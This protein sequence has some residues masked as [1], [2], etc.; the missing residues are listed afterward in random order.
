MIRTL[1]LAGLVF[2]GPIFA[3][4]SADEI[5]AAMKSAAEFYRGKIA[6]NGGYVYYT[7]PDYSKRLG[8]GVAAGDQ[9]WVQPPGTPSV[10][11]AYLKAFQATGD[12]F[13]LDSAVETAEALIYGQLESGAWTNSISFDPSSGRTAQ[14][15]NGKG[16]GRNF[17]TLDDGISQEAIQF[18]A[19]L[20]KETRFQNQAVHEAAKVALDALLNAQFPNGAFPQGWDETPANPG[21]KPVDLEAGF[22]EYDWKTE[23]RI[24]EY[25]DMYTLNDDL[26]LTVSETLLVAHKAYGEDRFANSLKQFGDF[27]IRAQ[28]PEPQPGWAQQYNYDMKP[29]WARKFEPA[30]MSGRETEGVIV[31]LMRIAVEFRDK[32]YLEPIPKA[33]Q[34]LKRSELPEEKFARYYELITN[35]P[36]YM[37]RQGKVYTLT[38]DDSNLP[39]HYGWKTDSRLRS[40]GAAY[41]EVMQSGKLPPI[42]KILPP[43]K[44]DPTVADVLSSLDSEGRWVSTFQGEPL[45]GQPKFQPG[46]KYIDSAVFSRNLGILSDA[47]SAD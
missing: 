24:K 25:W 23:G 31:T 26:A 5:K 32:K 7:S 14:Y 29:I 33:L 19:R 44:P 16:K 35:Q 17:S 8:E 11:L 4:Q 38:H 43:Q 15:R 12:K 20:D 30:A 1:I 37:E 42:E 9:I 47:L 34:W 28:M 18:L 2:C 10:G 22:P 45:V 27:L 41:R 36:L 40:I 3:Q 13:Y 46:E 6:R 21:G 39:S